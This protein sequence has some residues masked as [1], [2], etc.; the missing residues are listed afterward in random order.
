MA[1]QSTS[2]AVASL[3]NRHSHASWLSSPIEKRLVVHPDGHQLA[4]LFNHA[5]CLHVGHAQHYKYSYT[6]AQA[7][8]L[9][10]F[11]LILLVVAKEQALNQWL[12][13][14]LAL[15]APTARILIVGEKRG[16]V[17]SLVKKLPKGYAKATKLASG[18]HCQLFETHVLAQP[19]SADL[20]D[21]LPAFSVEWRGISATF[22]T[23]PGVFSQGRLDAGTE[24][25]LDHLPENMQ[26][27]VM[28][29]ACGSGVIGAMVA[30]KFKIELVASDVS[31]MAIEST[32]C[33]WQSIGV[34]GDLLL[35]DGLPSLSASGFQFILS[36]PPFH[37]GLRT[38]YDIGEQFIHHAYQQLSLG[39]EL[40]IVANRFLPWPEHIQ[41]VFGHCQTIA[42]DGKFKVLRSK[43]LS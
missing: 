21:D 7:P 19:S 2:D 38:D 36:N 5:W 10:H 17:T 18:N 25:L 12:L 4:P 14:Q 43:R 39:G 24:L 37:T 13:Q 30:R 1:V 29:F 23:L 31:P 40:I 8:S 42:D 20:T 26:G 27:K 28:D 3:L 33:N 16:G 15:Q 34:E 9:N 41:K 35:A 22:T 11:E 6:E 32:R